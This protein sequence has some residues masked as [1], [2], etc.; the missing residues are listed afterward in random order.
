M[1]I[2][3]VVVVREMAL[4]LSTVWLGVGSPIILAVVL[5]MCVSLVWLSI[6]NLL[7]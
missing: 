2:S 5:V 3:V 1:I 4:L 6:V 7:Q